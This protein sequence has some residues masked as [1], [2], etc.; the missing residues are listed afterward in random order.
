MS[1]PA[2]YQGTKKVPAGC[3]RYLIIIAGLKGYSI[4]K[5]CDEKILQLTDCLANK[6]L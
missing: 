4:I 6:N 1:V 3:G 5:R 2:F